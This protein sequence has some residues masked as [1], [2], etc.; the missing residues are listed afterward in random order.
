MRCPVC[1][2]ATDNAPLCPGCQ[3][4]TVY[5]ES[6]QL[7]IGYPYTGVFE[8]DERARKIIAEIKYRKNR[9]LMPFIQR[10]L[11]RHAPAARA[12]ILIPVPLNPV[13]YKERGFNQ[14]AELARDYAA[15]YGLQLRSDIVYRAKN[16]QKLAALSPDLRRA[17]LDYVFKVWDNKQAE[18]PDKKILIVDD[19]ITTGQ[20]VKT[21]AETLALYKPASIEILGV[22]RPRL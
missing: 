9:E 22:F 2:A 18:L 12:E 1:G 3:K 13:R 14:T 15:Y 4:L 7:K 16:T 21:L 5:N 10:A 20:T 19:I 6:A 17:E 11:L 8:Y